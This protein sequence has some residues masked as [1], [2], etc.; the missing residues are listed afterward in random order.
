[1][2]TEVHVVC[3]NVLVDEDQLDIAWMLS[4]YGDVGRFATK[5][6]HCKLFPYKSKSIRYNLQLSEVVSL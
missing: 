1:M 6:F 4:V 2:F 3:V 5:L